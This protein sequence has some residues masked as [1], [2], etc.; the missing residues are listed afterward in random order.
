MYNGGLRLSLYNSGSTE[1]AFNR[2]IAEKVLDRLRALDARARAGGLAALRPA[3]DPL[4][5]IGTEFDAGGHVTK[6][7]YG[8][9]NLSWQ[10]QEHPEWAEKIAAEVAEIRGKIRET[11]GVELRYLIWAGMGGSIEDKSMYQALGLLKKGPQFYALDST[12]PAKLK[13]ILGDMQGRSKRPLGEILR[14]TLVVGMAMGMTSYEPVVNLEKLSALYAK[15]GVDSRPNFLYL[16]LPG[17]GRSRAGVSTRWRSRAS[18]SARGLR[19]R[20]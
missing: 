10:A 13:H 2:F 15:N 18:I 8:I 5:A 16:T 19:A 3:D 17:S 4:V 7:S 6:N 12:D 20:F 11:H 1:T 14:S 9:F